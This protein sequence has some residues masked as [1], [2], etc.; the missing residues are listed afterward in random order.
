M[1]TGIVPGGRTRKPPDDDIPVVAPPSPEVPPNV[2]VVP[3][4]VVTVT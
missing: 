1:F 2:T 3:E 4:P